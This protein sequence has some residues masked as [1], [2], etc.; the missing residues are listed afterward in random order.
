MDKELLKLICKI[1]GNLCSNRL[2]RFSI[3]D[4]AEALNSVIIFI[5]HAHTDDTLMKDYLKSLR[6]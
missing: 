6:L 3:H 4:D 1:V 5:E 2:C